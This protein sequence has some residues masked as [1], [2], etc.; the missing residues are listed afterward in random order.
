MTVRDEDAGGSGVGST[1]AVPARPAAGTPARGGPVDWSA[2]IITS[3][4]PVVRGGGGYAP[5]EP[6]APDRLPAPILVRLVV[7]VLVLAVVLALGGLAVLHYHPSWLSFLRNTAGAQPVPIGTT[8]PG[9]RAFRLV[10]SGATGA[11]YAVPAS[12]YSLSISTTLPC[13]T[14]VRSPASATGFVVAETLTASTSPKVVAI[15]GTSSVELFAG[16]RSITVKVGARVL[17]TIDSPRTGY[18]YRFDPTAR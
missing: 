18:T 6:W 12:A 3:E 16:A 17:G 5:A 15:R 13:W 9:P 2:A 10:S 8:A 11:T 7:W 1:G 4:I 14:Q